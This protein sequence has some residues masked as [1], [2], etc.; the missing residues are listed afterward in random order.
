MAIEL[1]T[2]GRTRI[3]TASGRIRLK[4]LKHLAL[5]LYLASH[6]ER[7][8]SKANVTALLWGG[9]GRLA[10]QSLNQAVYQLRRTLDLGIESGRET[11][12]L[13]PEQLRCDFDRLQ[14]LP[15]GKAWPVV[16]E[17]Y[18]GPFAVGLARCATVGFERW[19][20]AER[21]RYH[22]LASMAFRAARDS[23]R[24][25]ENWTELLEMSM[26]WVRRFPLDWSAQQGYAYAL[27][28]LGRREEAR[29]YLRDLGR[30]RDASAVRP[31]DSAL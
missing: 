21:A 8:L 15:R 6:P 9:D 16:R 22:S 17:L 4:S 19:V 1:E 10:R 12:R 23:A 28:R 7:D 13:L 2:L 20:E 14:A 3:R 26:V 24:D 30:S 31:F 11:L 27:V 5:L 25:H 29:E 18:W